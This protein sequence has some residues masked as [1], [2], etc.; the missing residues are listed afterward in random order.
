MTPVTL[1]VALLAGGVTALVLLAA[2]GLT[3]LP[4]LFGVLLSVLGGGL[5]VGAFTRSGRGLIPVALLVAALTWGALAAP[6]DRIAAGPPQ[7]TAARADDSGRA[8]AAVPQRRWLDRAG[9]AP[10]G[11]DRAAGERP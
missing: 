3:D 4:V 6:L 2:G 1:A 7:G 9:P 5:V 8:R 11:P 10:D